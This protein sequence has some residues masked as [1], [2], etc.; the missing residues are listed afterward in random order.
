MRITTIEIILLALAFSILSF[1]VNKKFGKR[2]RLK[3]I[4]REVNDYNKKLREATLKKDEEAL[5]KLQQDEP[6][7][8]E[9]TKEMLFLPF[10]SILIMGPIFLIIFSVLPMLFPNYLV[11][12]P[13]PLLGSIWPITFRDV[14]GVKGLFL[15]S[16]LLFGI[17]IELIASYHEKKIL[18]EKQKSK[19]DS[20]EEKK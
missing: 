12:T 2:D 7:I 10:R 15:Y 18:A 5:K 3:E 1:Y 6:R 17:V 8:M 9:L 20:N 11:K 13:I 4:Q 16:L 14:F 19:G